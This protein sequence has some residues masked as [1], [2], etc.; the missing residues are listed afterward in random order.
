MKSH[1]VLVT[2]PPMLGMFEAFV[3]PALELGLELV[4]AEVT[5]TLSKTELIKLVPQFDGWIIGDDPATQEVFEAGQRGC[6]KAA[7]KWGIGVDNVDFKACEAFGIPITNTPGMFGREVADVAV[8]YVIALARHTVDIDRGV[9]NGGWPKPRGL[10]LA[11]RTVAI[12]GYGDIGQNTARRLMAADM[13]L[14]A[15]D[16]YV[17]E[18]SLEKGVSLAEW[19][20][21]LENADFVVVNCALTASSH[22]LLN[23]AAFAAMKPGVRIVNVGRGPVIDEEAL[24]S[25][26]SSGQ[27]HSAALDVFEEEPLPSESPLRHHPNCIFGSHNGSNTVDGVERTSHRAIQLIANF[28][29]RPRHENS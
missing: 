3:A 7:V 25:A 15:Y 9:R 19:P 1:R 22:H 27:V 6:L 23:E 14:I 8:G 21:R 13:N 18:A 11:G 24:I 26:L 17:K 16:P 10:S 20:K 29:K 28:L 4:P 2:C 12:V 5:Q